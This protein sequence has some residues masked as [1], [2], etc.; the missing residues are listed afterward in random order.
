MD[1]LGSRLS[2]IAIL[3]PAG[4]VS[5]FRQ[6]GIPLPFSAPQWG[7]NKDAFL[8]SEENSSYLGSPECHE[9]AFKV[10]ALW[11]REEIRKSPLKNSLLLAVR[12]D[13]SLGI[14][15]QKPERHI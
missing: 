2:Q 11:R 3:S 14:S 12:L 10:D 9:F 5:V 1:W 13:F 4:T 7:E 15:V 6:L 8:T